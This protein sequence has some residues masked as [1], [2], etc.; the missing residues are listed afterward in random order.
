MSGRCWQTGKVRY[1]TRIGARWQ[2]AG[3]VLRRLKGASHRREVR[4]YHC[5]FCGGVHLTSQAKR[6]R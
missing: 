4:T 5:H 2:L 3:I 1:T 6:S